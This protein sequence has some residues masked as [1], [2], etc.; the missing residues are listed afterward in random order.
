MNDK[1]IKEVEGVLTERT[2]K[3]GAKRINGVSG[4][5]SKYSLMERN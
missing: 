3:P 5:Y 1:E 2:H 4:E